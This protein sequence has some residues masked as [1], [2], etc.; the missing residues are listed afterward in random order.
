MKSVKTCALLLSILW[1]A[2]AESAAPSLYDRLGG[3]AGV[4]AIADSLID[5][6]AADPK[7]GM[8]FEDVN[9]KRVKRLLA[10]QICELSGGPCKYSGSPM[11]ET[12][13]GLHI[14]EA[15]FYSMVA[16]LRDVLE[17][18]HVD[19]AATNELLKILAPMKRD[20]VDHSRPA[21]A[22]PADADRAPP[23]SP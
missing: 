15:D 3:D 8:S 11:R 6:V 21:P 4:H 5:R 1:L 12:H 19:P 9:L 23:V 16:V 7:H 2:S 14:T 20:V 17:R 10:E 22:V 18:R 13:A